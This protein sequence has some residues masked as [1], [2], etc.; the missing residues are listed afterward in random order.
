MSNAPP[1]NSK[2]IH[3]GVGAIE[4]LDSSCCQLHFTF[5]LL[6]KFRGGEEREPHFMAKVCFI[7]ADS[8]E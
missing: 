3:L 6:A 8:N 2:V 4:Q 7:E 5:F 1:R